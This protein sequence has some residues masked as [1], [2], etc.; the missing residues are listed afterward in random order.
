MKC[1][2]KQIIIHVNIEFKSFMN[3]SITLFITKLL[4]IIGL[5]AKNLIFVLLS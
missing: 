4:D 2:L 3:Y 1:E 5:G